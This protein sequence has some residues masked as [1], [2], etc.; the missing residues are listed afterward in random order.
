MLGVV[1]CTFRMYN[2]VLIGGHVNIQETAT[3]TVT[4][5]CKKQHYY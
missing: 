5:I 2:F 4:A 1:L 3:V